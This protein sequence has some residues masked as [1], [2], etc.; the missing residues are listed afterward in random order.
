MWVSWGVTASINEK[1]IL[2][3]TVK[4]KKFPDIVKSFV[5]TNNL[6]HNVLYKFRDELL[7]LPFPFFYP[8]G[9][10]FQSGNYSM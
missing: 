7:N 6:N 2:E 3:I 4:N 1:N 10:Y 8:S 5:W 9:K